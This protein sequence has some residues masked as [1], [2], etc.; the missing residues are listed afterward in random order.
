MPWQLSFEQDTEIDGVGTARADYLDVGGNII[1]TH[2]GRLDERDGA[3]IDEFLQSAL[4]K[5]DKAVSQQ[6]K[7]SEVLQ[8]LQTLL[9]EKIGGK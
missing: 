6:A 1:A 9:D 5:Y 4:D 2:Q 8:K 3:S 7:K